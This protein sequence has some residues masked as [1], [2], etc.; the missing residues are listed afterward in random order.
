MGPIS[1]LFYFSFL[2]VRDRLIKQ[3]SVYPPDIAPE[4][5]KFTT[6]GTQ[7]IGTQNMTSSCLPCLSWDVLYD[8]LLTGVPTFPDSSV[9]AARNYCR[10][11]TGRPNGPW[12]FTGLNH[13]NWQYCTISECKKSITIIDIFYVCIIMSACLRYLFRSI[14]RLSPRS[15]SMLY[16]NILT[17][18]II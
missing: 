14:G 15:F 11:P 12:C 8:H 4:E 9:T 13:Q 6:E 17:S 5:C 18:M 1:W 10:N 16:F 3:R 2:T 7:Y